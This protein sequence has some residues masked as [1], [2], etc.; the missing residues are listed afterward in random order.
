MN[1]K[2]LNQKSPLEV[3]NKSCGFI[4]THTHTARTHTHTHTQKATSENVKL[5]CV[6]NNLLRNVA[7]K[8]FQSTAIE[9]VI[10]ISHWPLNFG[11]KFFVFTFG[12]YLCVQQ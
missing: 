3:G 9:V 12:I 11:S 2:E 7:V 4:T 1:G 8:F 6:S 10:V 5:F